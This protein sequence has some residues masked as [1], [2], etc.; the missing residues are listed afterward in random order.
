MN[1]Q[2]EDGS[3]RPKHVSENFKFTYLIK[4]VLDHIL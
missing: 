3:K 4:L 2:P 1:L